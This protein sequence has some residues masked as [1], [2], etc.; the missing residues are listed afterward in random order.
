MFFTECPHD[1]GPIVKNNGIYKRGTYCQTFNESKDEFDLGMISM[2]YVQM[3]KG[4]WCVLRVEV[5]LASDHLLQMTF[6]FDSRLR[7]SV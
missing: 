1:N 7:N 3:T 5:G 4:V 2:K 6:T